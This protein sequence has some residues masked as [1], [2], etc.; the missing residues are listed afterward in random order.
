MHD[1]CSTSQNIPVCMFQL[2]A[3]VKLGINIGKTAQLC[4][5]VENYEP[6][7]LNNSSLLFVDAL[8]DTNRKAV[9]S[10]R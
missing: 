2:S 7:E 6:C 1:V 8:F 4:E 9:E 3:A 5:Q 10:V